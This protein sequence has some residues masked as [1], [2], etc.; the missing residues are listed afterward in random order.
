MLGSPKS[1]SIKFEGTYELSLTEYE[2]FV[3][4]TQTSSSNFDSSEII[5]F[6]E[7]QTFGTWDAFMPYSVLPKLERFGK[8]EVW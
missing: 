1:Y 4:D 2:L 5:G 3:K 8:F 7:S 6:V